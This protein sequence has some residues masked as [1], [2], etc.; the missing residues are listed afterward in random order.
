M[1]RRVV[2]EL[3]D[4]GHAG[5]GR[6]DPARQ[7]YAFLCELNARGTMDLFVIR[8]EAFEGI[9]GGIGAIIGGNGFRKRGEF[10]P[11]GCFRGACLFCIYQAVIFLVAL[12]LTGSTNSGIE[13][14]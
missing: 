2:G 5:G 7:D 11:D 3:A 4:D 8:E 13:T 6:S 1:R 10:A 9:R 14:F 12:L